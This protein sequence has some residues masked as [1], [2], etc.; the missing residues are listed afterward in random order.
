MTGAD[1]L[2]KAA[3]HINE[4]YVFRAR[5]PKD[6]PN[7]RGPWNCSE[8]ASWCVFQISNKL[9]GCDDDNGDPGLADAYTGYWKR[10][11]QALGQ[12]ISVQQAAVTPG[13]AV[14]R[15]P[16]PGAIGHVVFSDGTGGTIEAH[17]T[18]TG[19]IRAQLADRR[20]DIGVLVPGITY[21]KNDQ[22]VPAP[23][24]QS[25]IYHLASPNMEGDA[26]KRIQSALAAKGID[27]GTIDGIY[28]PHTMAAVTAFQIDNGLVP[29]GEVGPETAS[30]LGVRLS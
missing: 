9:Y 8:F 15:F 21:S 25:I 2:D 14:L 16:V 20:W 23:Q 17:S 11:A 19:V 24:P 27:P 28:G 5:V 12:I 13:A 7:W 18:N 10:D 1:V 26:V 4:R 29:D 3:K 6:N 22:L 30:A